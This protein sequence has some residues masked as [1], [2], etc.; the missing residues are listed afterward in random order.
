MK[1]KMYIQPTLEAV[2]MKPQTIICA[3]I[4]SGGKSSEQ[5]GETI[6]E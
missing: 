4:T 3:S 2:E 1:K 6:A 5:S